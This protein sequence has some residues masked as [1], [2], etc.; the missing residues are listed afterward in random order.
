LKKFEKE[1]FTLKKFEEKEIFFFSWPTPH[2]Y[3]PPLE[4]VDFL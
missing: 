3:V 1:K 4:L 2:L